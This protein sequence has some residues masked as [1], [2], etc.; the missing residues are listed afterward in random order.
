[1][2][3]AG[4]EYT[5]PPHTHTKKMEKSQPI[6][7]ECHGTSGSNKRT[8]SML[9]APAWMYAIFLHIK[10]TL[11]AIDEVVTLSWAQQAKRRKRIR[12]TWAQLDNNRSK[13]FD[14]GMTRHV[15]VGV[16][17]KKKREIIWGHFRSYLSIACPN[18]HI[19]LD[20]DGQRRWASKWE[21]AR[22]FSDGQLSGSKWAFTRA[23]KVVDHDENKS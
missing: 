17:R 3:Y 16:F 11:S 5:P 23:W 14:A 7:S 4:Y 12:E 15:K 10:I 13:Q 18:D 6:N 1:M 22:G 19:L 8:N 2:A 21:R 9:L 20:N